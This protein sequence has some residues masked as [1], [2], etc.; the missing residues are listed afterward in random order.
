MGEALLDQATLEE[1]ARF[2]TEQQQ[3]RLRERLRILVVEDQSFSR[4]LLCQVAGLH[5]HYTVDRAATIQEGMQL[6]LKYAPDIAFLDIELADGS[7]HELAR[8]IKE[9]DGSAY[10]VMVTGNNYKK[11]VEAA[12]NNRVD[13]FIA[14]PFNKHRIFLSIENFLAKRKT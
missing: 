8:L 1:V 6:Y 2:E 10:V 11:D 5:G 14:K 7:G 4:T 13:D 9:I 12:K 3:R